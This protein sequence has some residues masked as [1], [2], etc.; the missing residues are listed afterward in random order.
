MKLTR[1]MYL[2]HLTDGRLFLHYFGRSTDCNY[3]LHIGC[4]KKRQQ[5]KW[6]KVKVKVTIETKDKE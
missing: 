3:P 1:T 2:E 5:G 6:Q 4:G